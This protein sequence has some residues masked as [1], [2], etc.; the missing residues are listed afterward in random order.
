MLIDFSPEFT[1]SPK[2]V[3]LVKLSTPLTHAT[4]FYERKKRLF[5]EVTN[6]DSEFALEEECH[7]HEPQMKRMKVSSLPFAI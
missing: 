2:I 7:I 1:S 6:A 4:S 5:S 3:T